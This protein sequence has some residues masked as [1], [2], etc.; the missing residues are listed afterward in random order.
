MF[1]FAVRDEGDSKDGTCR[2][3]RGPWSQPRVQIQRRRGCAADFPRQRRRP[4][5]LPRLPVPRGVDPERRRRCERRSSLRAHRPILV[6]SKHG[7]TS[8]M[9]EH[10]LEIL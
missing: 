5:A 8:V 10:E 6:A 2:S 1:D 4:R 3:I 9:H 7:L